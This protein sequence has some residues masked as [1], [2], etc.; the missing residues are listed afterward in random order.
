M[1][2]SFTFKE[3][4]D[5]FKTYSELTVSQG[6]I[7]FRPGTRKN[8]KTFVQ[9]TKDEIH[10]GRD[11]GTTVFQ[12]DRVSN[13]IQ[14]YKTHEKFVNYSKALAD[15]AKPDKFKDSAKCEI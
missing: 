5:H 11:P 15:A 10:L 8:I 7:C 1:Y 6:Q 14:S 9:L 2:G 13:L 4:D 3:L 12:V